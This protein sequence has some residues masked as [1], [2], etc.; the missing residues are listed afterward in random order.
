[1]YNKSVHVSLTIELGYINMSTN[2]FKIGLYLIY[3]KFNIL[4]ELNSYL[5]EQ[6]IKLSKDSIL[7][8]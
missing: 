1:M 5:Q 7:T 6:A 4:L 2:Y 3:V 8:R